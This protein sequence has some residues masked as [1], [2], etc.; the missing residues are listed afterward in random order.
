MENF[1]G[2]EIIIVHVSIQVSLEIMIRVSKIW[3]LGG[4]NSLLYIIFSNI[5]NNSH[6]L[7]RSMC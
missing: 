7:V 5:T 4:H 6:S 2:A 3:D 1:G